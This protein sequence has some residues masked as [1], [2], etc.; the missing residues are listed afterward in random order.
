MLRFRSASLV[1]VV[2]VLTLGLIVGMGVAGGYEHDDPDEG[3]VAVDE[4]TTIEE[5]GHYELTANVTEVTANECILIRASDVVFDGAG[6]HLKGEGPEVGDKPIPI[7]IGYSNQYHVENVTVTNVTVTEWHQGIGISRASNSTVKHATAIGNG[8]YGI[9]IGQNAFDN[10]IES[11]LVTHSQNNG[12]F[13]AYT[14]DN[15]RIT[16]NT[17]RYNKNGISVH[18]GQ[19]NLVAHNLAE[20]NTQKGIVAG[21]GG[22]HTTFVNN[23]ARSNGRLGIQMLGADHNT[24]RDNT[25]V[26]NAEDG[27][28]LGNATGTTLEHNTAI[29]NE[30]WAFR[31]Q[32][33][34]AETRVSN[35][36]V[37][38]TT[39]V[40]FTGQGV[41]FRAIADPPAPPTDAHAVF[42][43]VGVRA[44][45]TDASL[46]LTFEIDTTDLDE[47]AALGVWRHDDGWEHLDTTSI[48][49]DR[50]Q[51]TVELEA[52]D[53]TIALLAETPEPANDTPDP[54]A[55]P[56]TDDTADD[57][58]DDTSPTDPTDEEPA[59][60]DP[61]GVEQPGFHLT[62]TILAVLAAALL[63]HRRRP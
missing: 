63:A 50:T 7:R 35:L 29:E 4:C 22:D 58:T 36:R 34:T 23:T 40:S 62:V 51:V 19:G 12:I 18:D 46:S 42:A 15:N 25:V 53:A 55:A 20:N 56:T 33:G 27:F 38:Q 31:M 41:A 3:V 24:L 2:G 14:A 5:P 52:L 37:D 6:H 49:A 32:P 43:A 9:Y 39:T 11:S 47:N 45:E 44:T 57:P 1:V 60:D 17:V 59:A 54:R 13:V 61:T 48:G 30:E 26:G 8:K 16:N 28:L 21:A 10:T